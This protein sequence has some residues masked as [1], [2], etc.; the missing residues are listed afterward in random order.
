M[1]IQR[2]SI[3]SFQSC[4]KDSA[5]NFQ[6]TS[7]PPR[8][9]ASV[10]F[11]VSKL[12]QLGMQQAKVSAGWRGC[13]ALGWACWR[14]QWGFGWISS[15]DGEFG[16]EVGRFVYLLIDGMDSSTLTPIPNSNAGLYS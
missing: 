11:Q 15:F 10:L 12:A 4:F 9:R 5:P 6:I 14:K 13:R 8:L 1:Y 7:S 2:T 3:L 16:T